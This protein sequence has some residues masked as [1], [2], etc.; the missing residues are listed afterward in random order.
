MEKTLVE[1]QPS[2]TEGLQHCSEEC[3]IKT[4]ELVYEKCKKIDSKK[5]KLL[6][7]QAKE[8]S[9]VLDSAQTHN[10]PQEFVK[11]HHAS[12]SKR[13][14]E[15]AK[16]LFLTALPAQ[17]QL[18]T[19]QSQRLWLDQDG[20]LVALLQQAEANTKRQLEGLR[21][22][23][24]QDGQVWCEEAVL[25]LACLRHLG[26]QQLKILRGMVV[27]QSYVL[28]SSHVGMLIMKKQHLLL[29]AVQRHFVAR[30]F[31][32]R[33]LKEMRLSKLK[34]LSQSDFSAL[35]ALVNQTQPTVSP[36]MTKA[37]HQVQ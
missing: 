4:K 36:T 17:S 23:L 24:E 2:L 13:L 28:N 16:D 34:V 14:G 3:R 22:Q 18:S 35:L 27:R 8:R 25:V 26:E 29:A 12:W 7:T 5:K 33:V 32:L 9:R 11:R 31:C 6:R 19:D 10:D 1:L 30:H 15:L 37:Q 20:E 21:A